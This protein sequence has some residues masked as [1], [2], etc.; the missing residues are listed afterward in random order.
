MNKTIRLTVPDWQAGNNPLYYLGSQLLTALVPNNPNQKNFTV[1]ITAPNEDN[2]NLTRENGVTAQSIVK[3]NLQETMKILNNEQPDK[4]ITLGGNCLVSQAPFDYLHNKYQG[5]VGILWIDAHPD[6]STPKI[7]P[8]EHAMVLGNLIH[9]GD[10]ELE[11]LVEHPFS[12]KEI[13]YVGLQKPTADENKILPDLGINYQTQ[14][15]IDFDKIQT[16]INENNFTKVLIHLDLDA[17]DPKLF[18]EQYFD[19]PGV[20]SYNV[21]HGALNP[22]EIMKLLN[23]LSD[24]TVGLT[25]AEYLPWSALQL[26]EIMQSSKI[27]D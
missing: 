7:F 1:P 13:M 2:T 3:K 11:K 25:I 17:L 6:I 12:P 26:K 14:N 27:F 8:N 4:V 16:W 18:H 19:Q 23:D 20:T 9:Q 21:S 10:K 15:K 22:N 5:H 24:K